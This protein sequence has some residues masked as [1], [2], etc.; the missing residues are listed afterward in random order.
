[1]ATVDVYMIII[2]F[3][4]SFN[5]W[6]CR[7]NAC[8]QFAPLWLP[9]KH[10]AITQLSKSNKT[11]TKDCLAQSQLKAQLFCIINAHL[12]VLDLT[13]YS[14]LS[15]RLICLNSF[16][17][18]NMFPEVTRRSLQFAIQETVSVP[19]R[20]TTLKQRRIDVDATSTYI[21]RWSDVMCCCVFT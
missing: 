15:W 19:S 7:L 2:I 12:N 18:M 21:R 9:D 20:H 4:S 6:V 1:M 13:H 8:L 11:I 10:A 16:V 5:C 3:K 14:L 17:I